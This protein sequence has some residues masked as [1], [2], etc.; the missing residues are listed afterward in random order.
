MGHTHL[1]RFINTPFRQN[2][3]FVVSAAWGLNSLGVERAPL[4]LYRLIR[5]DDMQLLKHVQLVLWGVL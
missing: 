4:R 5:Q 2:N 3:Y 1:F